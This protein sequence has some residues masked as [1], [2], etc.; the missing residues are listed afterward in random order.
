M[1]KHEENRQNMRLYRKIQVSLRGSLLAES[2]KW[3]E[4]GRTYKTEI[5]VTA[6][7]KSWESGNGDGENGSAE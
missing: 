6:T 7:I 1:A 4:V 5:N 2:P 3:A